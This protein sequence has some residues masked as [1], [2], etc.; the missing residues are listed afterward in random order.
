MAPRKTKDPIHP[1]IK[2]VLGYKPDTSD[3]EFLSDWKK[4][5]SKVCK[6]CW[7]LKYC[8]YGRFVEQ[9]PLIPP[10]RKDMEKHYEYYRKCLETGQKGYIGPIPDHE[11]QRYESTLILNV[12]HPDMV[13]QILGKYFLNAERI[14]K[15]LSKGKTL[16][17]VLG[18]D[19]PPIPIQ[20]LKAP[21]P[22]DED[23]EKIEIPPHIAKKVKEELKRMKLILKS[24]IFDNIK[25]LDSVT[26][27]RFKKELS[28]FDPSKYPE[29]IP[30]SV[31]EMKCNIFGHICPI[32]FTAE[33]ITETSNK[34][35]RSRYISFQTKMRVVRR[36]NHTCQHCGKHLRDDE[37]EFDH[38]I[39]I[40]KGGSSEEQNIRLTCFKCNRDKS[41]K[42]EI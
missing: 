27:K 16:K 28:G 9:S 20:A 4:C 37:V 26:R 24:G 32:I 14:E 38:K 12:K 31:S 34:R 1:V 23:E 42:I 5:S 33:N 39:P 2:E 6:P 30:E 11:K 29:Y 40:A 36:D 21:F 35:L 13:M 19:L 41:D 7:E 8:P 15:E 10:L 22:F 3:K 18:Y 25:P 17:E